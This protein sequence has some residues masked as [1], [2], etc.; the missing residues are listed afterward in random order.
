MN[1]LDEGET[2]DTLEGVIEVII[3]Y[4]VGQ[5]KFS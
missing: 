4:Y 5:F 2:E 3:D 1:V